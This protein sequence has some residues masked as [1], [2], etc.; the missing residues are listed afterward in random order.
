MS[1]IPLYMG[2][3]LIRKRTPR[4]AISG[5]YVLAYHRVLGGGV[6]SWARYPCRTGCLGARG[7]LS[8]LYRGTSLIS[9]STPVRPYSSPM[10]RT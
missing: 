9:N 4:W 2:T 5:P 7:A 10:A 8:P 3:S 6:F 1:E